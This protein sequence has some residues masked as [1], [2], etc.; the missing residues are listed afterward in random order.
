MPF[1]GPV[2]E[3][4]AQR[5]LDLLE[6]KRHGGRGQVERPCRA[7]DLAGAPDLGKGLQLSHRYR[8]GMAVSF[9][10]CVA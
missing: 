3:R 5:L 6:L 9:P 2:E 8:G 1:A 4:Q 10:Y 7:H